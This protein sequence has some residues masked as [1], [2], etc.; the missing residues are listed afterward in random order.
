[1]AVIARM[2]LLESTLCLDSLAN[3]WNINILSSKK[4]ITKITETLLE[5]I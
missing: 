1:M 5:Q 3:K 4:I 2:I